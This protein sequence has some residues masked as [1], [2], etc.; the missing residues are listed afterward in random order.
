[1]PVAADCFAL[2]IHGGAGT[3]RRDAMSGERAE[4]Y[5]AGLRAALMAGRAVLADGGS[6]LDG[7]LQVFGNGNASLATADDTNLPGPPAKGNAKPPALISPDPTLDFTVPAGTRVSVPGSSPTAPGDLA[8]LGTY[9]G[10]R[11]RA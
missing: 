6:A 9:R 1:M 5:H 4:L 2:V 10:R 3:L 11:T 7:V 8:A